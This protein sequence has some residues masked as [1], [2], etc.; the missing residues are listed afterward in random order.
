MKIL[1]V[2]FHGVPGLPD[3]QF[4][5]S[6]NGDPAELVLVTG[7][8]ASGKT[9]F[10]EAIAEA[11][12][13]IAAYGGR[14]GRRM[15][16]LDRKTSKVTIDWW[17]DEDER[18]IAGGGE[19]RPSEAL[20]GAVDAGPDT[21]WDEGLRMLLSRWSVEAPKVEYFHA[22]RRMSA[23]PFPSSAR[24]SPSA[25]LTATDAKFEG[26]HGAIVESALGIA[27]ETEPPTRARRFERAFEALCR[28][29]RFRGV[30]RRPE[31]SYAAFDQAA[32]GP[33]V[34]LH[35]L[36]ASEHQ[37]ALFAAAFS[38]LDI[39]RSTVL[40]DTPELGLHPDAAEDFLR[41]IASLGRNNQLIVAT[42]SQEIL[43]RADRTT[44]TVLQLRG[45]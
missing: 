14:P 23:P 30:A 6:R 25:R 22:L 33:W 21:A 12:E 9:A 37:A 20:F 16:R 18:V 40:I 38:L 29:R 17:L 10:L 5:L 3:A 8:A 44:T 42:T 31:G 24:V 36:S 43:T 1:S 19:R 45:A 41:G 26:L 7:P 27:A 13:S 2:S 39:D 11:K 28:T 35:E 15:T 4:D 32:G 34:A